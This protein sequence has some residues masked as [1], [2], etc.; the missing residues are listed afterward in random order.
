MFL[1]F[2]DINKWEKYKKLHNDYEYIYTSSN[3]SKNISDFLIR[4][5][6]IIF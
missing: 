6:L 2:L 1:D 4:L 3:K 5:I